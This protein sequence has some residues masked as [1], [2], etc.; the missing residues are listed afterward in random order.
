MDAI[1][2]LS[3]A[4]LSPMRSSSSAIA[5]MNPGGYGLAAESDCCG[6]G[7]KRSDEGGPSSCDV[8]SSLALS[9]TGAILAVFGDSA[10][11]RNPSM[12]AARGDLR[13]TFLRSALMFVNSCERGGS[14]TP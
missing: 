13:L 14:V 12:P 11:G 8:L 10:A 7:T 1:S 9:V 2:S 3:P 4:E 6:N 5:A